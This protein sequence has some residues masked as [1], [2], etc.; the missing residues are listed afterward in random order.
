MPRVLNMSMSNKK[1]RSK[2]AIQGYKS[3]NMKPHTY[4]CLYFIAYSIVYYKY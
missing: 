4:L 1:K 2:I 3:E